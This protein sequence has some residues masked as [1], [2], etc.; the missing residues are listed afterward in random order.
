MADAKKKQELQNER[1]AKKA[2][3]KMMVSKEE[4]KARTKNVLLAT[5]VIVL[6]AL[7]VLLFSYKQI[8]VSGVIERHTA[9]VSTENYS[10]SK[11]MMTYYFNT[12]YQNVA[13]YGSQLGLDT[14]KSLKSQKFGDSTWF[15]Y[16]LSQSAGQARQFLVLKEGA[17]AE[18]FKLSDEDYEEVDEV[19]DSLK[20]QAKQYNYPNVNSFVKM[21]YGSCVNI[22]DVRKCIE[23]SLLAEKYADKLMAEGQYSVE[24]YEKYFNENEDSYKYVDYLKYSFDATKD[25]ATGSVSDEEKAE[26]SAHAQELA[27][28]TSVDEFKAYVKDY[29]TAKKTAELKEGETLDEAAIQSE[30]DGVL[31]THNSKTGLPSVISAE[32]YSDEKPIGSVATQ[33][34][35][36]NG[37][38]TV[39]MKAS[40]KYIDDYNVRKAQTIFISNSSHTDAAGAAAFADEVIAKWNESDKS[41]AAFAELKE[42]YNEGTHSHGGSEVVK[43]QTGTYTDWLYDASRTAGEVDKVASTKDSGVY[44][45]YYAGEEDMTA[46]QYDADT[47][48]RNEYYSDKYEDFA[49]KYWVYANDEKLNGIN[50]IT[51]SSSSSN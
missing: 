17:A 4:K 36:E 51:M 47:A 11:S 10:V 22:K 13:S 27:A 6:L 12:M 46:W 43:K 42:E 15:D 29:L 5:F 39:Y 19:I 8:V 21:A 41:E 37:S 1:K 3:R 30:V 35:D 33:N 24:D 26:M 49:A 2:E 23:L 48:L 14:S 34:D 31:V 25:A 20:S 28:V 32:F 38:Y 44:I 50:P 9:A 16:I 7:A 45:V 40:D 18:G